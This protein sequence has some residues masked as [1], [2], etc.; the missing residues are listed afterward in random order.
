MGD[1][2]D[3]FRALKEHK[4]AVREK[5]GRDCPECKKKRPKAC[6]SILLPQQRCRVDGHIDPRPQ[7]TDEQFLSVGAPDDQV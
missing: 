3:D 6:P 1:V 7:L 5:F 4:K 2:G